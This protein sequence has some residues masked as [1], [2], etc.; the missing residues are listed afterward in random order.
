MPKGPH[1]AAEKNFA[2]L[3]YDMESAHVLTKSERQ[4]LR[5]STRDIHLP[6]RHSAALPPD[7]LGEASI[8]VPDLAFEPKIRMAT[9]YLVVEV[10]FSQAYDNPK[11]GGL[12]QDA[13]HWL[14]QTEGAVRCAV[15]VCIIENKDKQESYNDTYEQEEDE[16]MDWVSDADSAESPF[17]HNVSLIER[18]RSSPTLVSCYAGTFSAFVEVWRYNSTKRIFLAQ[19]RVQLG[20]RK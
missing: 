15:L 19:P 5:H 14:E 3:P 2:D 13:R 16:E 7:Y 11:T 20:G 6:Q 12:V 4:S 17:A 8:K 9:P 1:D 18:F 10:G